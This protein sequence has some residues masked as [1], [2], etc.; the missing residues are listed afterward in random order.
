MRSLF[1]RHATYLSEAHLGA[2]GNKNR[3]ALADGL[4]D[5]RAGT[6][7]KIPSFEPNRALKTEPRAEPS[8]KDSLNTELRAE[9]S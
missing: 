8:F 3:A 5:T 6:S 9:P 7:L 1:K 4:L 2:K